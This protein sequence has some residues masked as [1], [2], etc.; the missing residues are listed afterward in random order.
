M[1]TTY[2]QL[3]EEMLSLPADL[4]CELASL[5]VKSLEEAETLPPEVR[6]RWIKVAAKRSREIREGKVEPIPLRD[7]L[8]KVRNSLK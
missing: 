4:R 7:G 5:L 3:A 2:D 8:Q 6:D 1:A